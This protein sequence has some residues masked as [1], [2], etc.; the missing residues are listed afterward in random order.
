[1][2]FLAA[3]AS[4]LRA[5]GTPVAL[6]TTAAALASEDLRMRVSDGDVEGID[7]GEV[8]SVRDLV[9]AAAAVQADRP[10]AEVLVTE[11]D[12]F[13]PALAVSRAP[14]DPRR[15]RVLVMRAPQ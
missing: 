15:L 6:A 12:K 5:R 4:F 11:G 8:A 3:I 7:V 14:V 2:L 10:G 9:A 1:M 13:L